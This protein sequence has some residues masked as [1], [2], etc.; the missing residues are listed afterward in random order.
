MLKIAVVDANSY[1]SNEYKG[2]VSSIIGQWLEWEMS[3]FGMVPCAIKE[4]DVIFLAYAGSIDWRAECRKALKREGVPFEQPTRMG[5]PYIVTGGPIDANPL[6]ALDIADALCVGEAYRLVRMLLEMV[7]DGC[8]VTDLRR[9]F[10]EDPHAIE[11]SQVLGLERD[12]EKPWLL[13][14]PLDAPLASPDSYIDWRTPAVKSDDKVVRVLGSKGCHFKCSYCATTYRQQYTMNPDERGTRRLIKRLSRAGERVQLISNDP[15]NIPYYVDI[16]A[17]LDS[18]SYTIEEFM[19]AENRAAIIRQRPRI[20]RFGVEGISERMRYAW[21]KPIPNPTLLDVIGDLQNNQINSHMFLIVGAPFEQERD[22]D[23]WR[24]FHLALCRSMHWGLLRLKFTT[25]V[26]AAPAP[27]MRFAPGRGWE[28]RWQRFADWFPANVASNHIVIVGG[29][30]ASSAAV[31]VADQ[32]QVPLNVAEWLAAQDE[33]T[34]LAETVEEFERMPTLA[35]I[36]WPLSTK[37]RFRIGEKYRDRMHSTKRLP[38]IATV[39]REL[40]RR[41]QRHSRSEERALGITADESHPT[42]GPTVNVGI[43][44]GQRPDPHTGVTADQ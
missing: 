17:K 35:L 21:Q 43:G 27:L 16:S 31:D 38:K 26:P 9:M 1:A 11:A 8:A 28:A 25:F 39:A 14:R 41:G 23:E 24:E 30:R 37:A 20:V 18:G 34:V 2:V 13:A 33:T 10:I 5:L 22:W 12:R 15:A 4:A 6:T 44:P 19:S 42:A 3:R 29:R 36:Q 32:V 40:K 7:R